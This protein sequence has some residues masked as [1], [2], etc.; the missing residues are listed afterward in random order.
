MLQLS[1]SS[2]C[3]FCFRGKPVNLFFW[4]LCGEP[5]LLKSSAV[6]A[7]AASTAAAAAAAA[8]VAVAAAAAAD[9]GTDTSM[10]A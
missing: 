5:R 10:H 4:Q 9:V 7:N 8:A 3:R 2:Q 1:K 6:M